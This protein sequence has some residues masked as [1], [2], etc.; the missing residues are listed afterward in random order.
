M[1]RI[2]TLGLGAALL[3]ASATLAHAQSPSAPP[4]DAARD[5]QDIHQARRDMRQDRRDLKQ[6]R[7][8]VHQDGRGTGRRPIHIRVHISST[9]GRLRGRS[10][11]AIQGAHFGAP[12]HISTVD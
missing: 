9:A 5:A 11:N 8:D 1:I 3:L 2:R 12:P 6:D 4:A 10:G 7:R